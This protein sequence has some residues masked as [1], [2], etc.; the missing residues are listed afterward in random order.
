MKNHLS[1]KLAA[2]AIAAALCAVFAL[3]ACGRSKGTIK[4]GSKNFTESEIIAEIYALALEDAGYKVD[5]SFDISGSTIHTALVHGDI[6]LYPAYTG[7]ALLSVLKRP[8]QTDPQRVYA[9]VKKAYQQKWHIEWLDYAKASDSQGLAITTAA[10]EK[11]HIKTISDLQKHASRLRFASQGEFDERADGLPGLTKTYGA[12][13]WKSSKI[14]DNALK[15]QV[16]LKGQADVTPCYTTE[17]QLTNKKLTLLIDDKHFWPPY[18]VAPVVRSSVLK[19][20]PDIAKPLNAV[21]KHL[22][23]AT[24]TKLNARV[25][26]N[27]EDAEDVAK[28]FYDSIADDLK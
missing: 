23:T 4:V 14:Y 16:L 12:F 22:T 25:D 28:D 27:K 13:Q 9:T 2:V 26:V 19:A 18:N 7:T 15:Y 11:Y 17:G 6:D 8:L 1:L 3:S 5:R 24:L 20:H 10:A 21:S